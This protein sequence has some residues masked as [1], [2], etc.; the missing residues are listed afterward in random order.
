MADQITSWHKFDE[1]VDRWS[2]GH[3]I[4]KELIAKRKAL[5]CT[6]GV[7]AL[8]YSGISHGKKAIRLKRILDM[9]FYKEYAMGTL[10]DWAPEES[11]FVHELQVKANP[12]DTLMRSAVIHDVKAF[13]KKLIGR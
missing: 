8:I 1:Y 4:D 3:T 2:D 6:I 7:T 13:V 12:Y 9:P 10:P 11:V 5:T